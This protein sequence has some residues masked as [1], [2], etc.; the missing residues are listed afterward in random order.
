MER[1]VRVRRPGLLTTVQDTGR[2][3]HQA[4]GVPVAGP[5]DWRA[6]RLANVLAGN[7]AAAAALEI[8]LVGPE[9]EVDG[10]AVIGWAGADFDVWLGPRKVSAGR[11]PV[12]SGTTIRFGHRR[13]GARAA[14]A[15]GGGFIVPQVLGSRATDLR[16]RLDDR[17]RVLRAGDVLDLGADQGG[18]HVE[19]PLPPRRVK[20]GPAALRVLPAPGVD[21]SEEPFISLTRETFV[22]GTKSDRMAYRLE[23]ARLAGA[24]V[25]RQLSMP[26]VM[27]AVQ[28]PPSGEPLL[29]MADRQTTGGYRQVAVVITADLPEAG[30]LAP[31]D[32]VRFVACA[33]ADAIRSL[34]AEEQALLAL[35]QR[36]A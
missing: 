26:T 4:W 7:P 13:Q 17:L 23:G 27:G 2:W 24:D 20:P 36:L 29:L 12:A 16:S 30:Q 28:V 10:P 25:G 9:L 34:I 35:E 19:V 8:T 6:H 3:G 5:M 21:P 11:Y 1:R 32:P 18:R 15:I 31:G 22:V 33:Q 14:L